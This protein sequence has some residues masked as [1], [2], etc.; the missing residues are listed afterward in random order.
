MT[1]TFIKNKQIEL[2]Y[3]SRIPRDIA[4]KKDIEDQATQNMT[5]IMKKMHS[6]RNFTGPLKKFGSAQNYQN[7]N[8][9]KSIQL[10]NH[11]LSMKHSYA[12]GL[13]RIGGIQMKN[14][15]SLLH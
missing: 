5:N 4:A 1:S 11:C 7:A 14:M 8:L 10:E 12:E 13:G 15:N 2:K 3:K 9:A 6:P